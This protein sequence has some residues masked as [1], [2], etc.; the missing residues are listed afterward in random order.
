MHEGTVDMLFTALDMGSDGSRGTRV[1]PT[2]MKTATGGQRLGKGCLFRV[3]GAGHAQRDL[4]DAH[5][6]VREA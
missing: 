2:E 6:K 4:M 5:E 1:A 3:S